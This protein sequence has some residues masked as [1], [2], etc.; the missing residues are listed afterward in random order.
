MTREQVRALALA[1]AGYL[2]EP[3]RAAW[4]A[5][6]TTPPTFD[7]IGGMLWRSTVESVERLRC[8]G[9]AG[10][11][12]LIDAYLEAHVDVLLAIVERQR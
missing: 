12:P 7:A 5:R 9:I 1:H 11:R 2:G 4:L 3:E 10:E 6:T 8:L